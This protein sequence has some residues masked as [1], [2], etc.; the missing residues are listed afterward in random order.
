MQNSRED[1]L[2]QLKEI[3][4]SNT[5]EIVSTAKESYGNDMSKSAQN[6][7]TRTINRE[8]DREIERHYGEYNINRNLIE[9][10][11]EN[12][13]KVA[14]DEGRYDE[15]GKI[16]SDFDEKQKQN[17]KEFENNILN[18]IHN[19]TENGEKTAVEVTE[20]DIK[21][22]EK[23]G[24]EEQVRDH[25]R[26]FSRTIPSFLMGYGNDETTLENFDTVIPAEVFLEVTGITVEDFK[27]LRDG[28]EF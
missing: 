20:K 25:L 27:F 11:R 14:E 6:E 19:I 5:D 21:R 12:A 24:I 22:K 26:G 23:E 8:A 15:I 13:I 3:I 9:S 17:N 18:A 16:N 7:I 10:D 1:T 4:H 28:G 2:R